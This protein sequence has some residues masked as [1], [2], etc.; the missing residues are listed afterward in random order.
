[1]KDAPGRELKKALR[2]IAET[3]VCRFVLTGNQNL[4]LTDVEERDK[5]TVSTI[6]R[7]GGVLENGGE[8]SGL[9]RNSIACV[10]LNTCSLAMAEAERYL[11][12]LIDKIEPLLAKHGLS[13]REITIRMTGCPNGCGRPY[14]GEIGFVGKSLGKYNMYLG[15]AFDG[16]R[17]N[18]LFMENVAEERILTELDR[19]FSDYSANRSADEAFGDFCVRKKY[20]EPAG[21]G[22][23]F[24]RP[25]G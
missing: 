18:R 4:T 15:A 21:D 9:R 12:S 16:S 1:M 14:L 25:A 22:E 8:L 17:L 24:H 2:N 7:A 3:G 23:S 11:P 20:V 5:R 6:L 19:L 13:Q 10:A